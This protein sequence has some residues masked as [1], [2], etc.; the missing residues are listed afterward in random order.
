MKNPNAV[1]IF[2]GLFLIACAIFI[3]GGWRVISFRGGSVLRLNTI[4]GDVQMCIASNVN[5]REQDPAIKHC[6]GTV[7]NTGP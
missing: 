7:V 6:D 5:G 1:A 2:A 4:T 3:T